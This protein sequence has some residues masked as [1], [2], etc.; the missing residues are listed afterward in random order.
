VVAG[1]H[2]QHS[3]D[4]QKVIASR[5]FLSV[6]FG[7]FNRGNQGAQRNVHHSSSQGALCPQSRHLATTTTKS[8]GSAENK[9]CNLAR[10]LFPE[11]VRETLQ[12]PSRDEDKVEEKR[13]KAIDAKLFEALGMIGANLFSA[14]HA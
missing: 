12:G 14:P 10:P 13:R 8:L 9:F 1:L 11:S 5:D 3:R 2:E 4:Q 7:T 6:A